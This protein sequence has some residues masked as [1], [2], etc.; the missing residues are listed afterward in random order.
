MYKEHDFN[1]SM[2]W[3]PYL[4]KHQQVDK[5]TFHLY[6][7]EPDPVWINR[8][9]R[10][11]Y[12]VISAG[13]WFLR[14]SYFYVN[15]SL[16]GGLYCP[17]S[18]ITHMSYF[19]SYRMAFQSAFRAI[20]DG[21]ADFNGVTFLRTYVPSHFEGA[22]WDKGGDCV[23]TRPFKRNETVLLEEYHKRFRMIQ[24]EELKNAYDVWGRNNGTFKVI[25]AMNAMR[26]RP[27]GHPSKYGHPSS[28]MSL[29]NDCVHWCLP[30]PIDLWNDFLQELLMR[31]LHS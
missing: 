25:D 12:V 27:D 16:V 1:L 20:K 18:N 22:P 4:V 28:K 29:F 7:D 23:R 11:D 21:T 13:Q 19:F 26:L 6:L 17:E 9:R 30:G 8:I 2:S 31:E 5:N 14:P 15:K 3:S 24:L 10:A